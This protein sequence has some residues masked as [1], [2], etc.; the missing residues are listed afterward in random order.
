MIKVCRSCLA[1]TLAALILTVPIVADN[2]PAN[3]AAD[4]AE[5]ITEIQL[6]LKDGKKLS[7]YI[8]STVTNPKES[9]AEKLDGYVGEENNRQKLGD[10][11]INNVS[12]EYV[13]KSDNPY[14]DKIF[15]PI[16]KGAKGYEYVPDKDMKLKFTFQVGDNNGIKYKVDTT[17]SLQVSIGDQQFVISENGVKETGG[18]YTAYLP[19]HTY[20]QVKFISDGGL[21]EL[22]LENISRQR[23]NASLEFDLDITAGETTF[24]ARRK[25]LKFKGKDQLQLRAFYVKLPNGNSHYNNTNDLFAFLD[26]DEKNKENAL[27][28][29]EVTL[30]TWNDND[31]ATIPPLLIGKDAT[32]MEGEKF[33]PLSLIVE[34]REKANGDNGDKNKVKINIGDFSSDNPVE[35]RYKIKMEFGNV[36]WTS[37]VIVR[38]KQK[39]PVPAPQPLPKQQ[40]KTGNAYFDLGRYLL[41]TCPDSKCAKT[42]TSAKKDDVPN[43]AAA[44][45]N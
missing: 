2:D 17:K 6:T 45:N 10:G 15:W 23:S 13:D 39:P 5:P 29:L 38:A 12:F 33:D 35:G 7:N 41:P 26:L 30:K 28:P 9:L 40:E 24:A 21:E 20:R 22:Y 4:N 37:T 18:V 11:I 42:E 44:V 43:T 27:K 3:Q 34:F 8:G 25:D 14:P 36:T 31:P 32:I 19:L 16:R 1:A